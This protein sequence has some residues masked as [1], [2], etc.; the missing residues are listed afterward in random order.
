M[1]CLKP[2]DF[3][4][5]IYPN[6][7]ARSMR[8]GRLAITR[9]S[10]NT[11]WF[12]YPPYGFGGIHEGKRYSRVKGIYIRP[13]WRG[14]GHGTTLTLALI[15]EA[16]KREAVKWIEA[17]TVNARWYLDRGFHVVVSARERNT[18]VRRDVQDV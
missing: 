4:A 9:D 18:L 12:K 8:G 2:A 13:E 7:N 16:E 11:R 5:D 15:A 3:R 1:S 10:P 6:R 17:I 14:F